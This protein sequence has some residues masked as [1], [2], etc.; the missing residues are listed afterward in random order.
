MNRAGQDRD[1]I[2]PITLYPSLRYPSRHSPFP[3]TYHHCGAG[4]VVDIITPRV[5]A[6]LYSGAFGVCSAVRKGRELGQVRWV[7][8]G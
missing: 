8:A 7:G 6:D 2:I 3:I 4:L 1:T 5:F